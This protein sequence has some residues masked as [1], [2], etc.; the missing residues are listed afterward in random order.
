MRAHRTDGRG[1][2]VHAAQ[3]PARRTA[4][5]AALGALLASGLAAACAAAPSTPDQTPAHQPAGPATP[6]PD[7]GPPPPPVSL[8][9]TSL[10]L[11]TDQAAG[12]RRPI[13][14]DEGCLYLKLR[15]KPKLAGLDA[16]VKFAVLRDG[17]VGQLSFLDPVDP[18]VE[19]L[20]AE[21][22]AGCRWVPATDPQGVP[23]AVWVVQPLKI[24]SIP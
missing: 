19:T 23:L 17:S 24:G 11:G 15:G 9:G 16:K 3:R 7:A 22:F 4:A 2:S 14:A 21:A 8:D 18:E 1:R 20:V 10:R 5:A 13:P 12:F 6:G